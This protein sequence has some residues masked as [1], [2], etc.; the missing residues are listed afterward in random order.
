MSNYDRY[1]DHGPDRLDF[2]TSDAERKKGL[3][4]RGKDADEDDILTLDDPISSPNRPKKPKKRGFFRKLLYFFF[5]LMLLGALCAAGGGY[6]LYQWV[7]DD[8][9]SFSK[10]AD[11]RP[12]PVTTVL[13]RAGSPSSCRSPSS[14]WKT[15][16]STITPAWTSKPSSAR[17]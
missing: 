9:P 14:P 13:A 4:R 2:G 16:S 8:L 11:Y 17:P 7:S 3:F 1:N 12:P 5:S 6:M 10:I 15:I